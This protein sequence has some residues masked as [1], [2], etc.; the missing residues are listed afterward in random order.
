MKK[1]L[2]SSLAIFLIAIGLSYAY[3]DEWIMPF[4][5]DYLVKHWIDVTFMQNATGGVDVIVAQMSIFHYDQISEVPESITEET[6]KTDGGYSVIIIDIKEEIDE[7]LNPTEPE[8]EPESVLTPEQQAGIDEKL[9]ELE[10]LYEDA[11]TCKAYGTE[12]NSMFQSYLEE[13][14][15]KEKVAFTSLPLLSQ[16]AA[17]I[18]AHEACRVFFEVAVHISDDRVM[19]DKFKAQQKA[20]REEVQR[21][22]DLEVDTDYTDPITQEDIDETIEDAE[23]HLIK[24]PNFY[25]DPYGECEPAGSERC[26]NRGGFTTDESGNIVGAECGTTPNETGPPT[27]VCPLTDYNK[28]IA[29]AISAEDNYANIEKLVCDKYM[30]QYQ[31]LV[32]RILAGDENAQLPHWLAHCEVQVQ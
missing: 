24:Y 21:L 8:P 15:S 6:E 11:A 17:L 20:E 4:S 3:A 1:I 25:K 13:K 7:I 27:S 26:L 2:F 29:S 16:E 32:E 23:A 12:G 18:K 9:A 14:I 31:A 30:N 5:P 22:A 10:Q 28:Q 19:F